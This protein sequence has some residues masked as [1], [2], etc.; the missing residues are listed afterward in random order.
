MPNLQIVDDELV[1]IPKF[2]PLDVLPPN[3]M[4]VMPSLEQL[5]NALYMEPIG[6]KD[7]GYISKGKKVNTD[8]TTTIPPI[9]GPN[10]QGI[11]SLFKQRKRYAD[12]GGLTPSWGGEQS[13]TLPDGSVLSQDQ[14]NELYNQLN[15]P[16]YKKLLMSGSWDNQPVTKAQYVE[17]LLKNLGYNIPT[18][19]TG[20]STPT[21]IEI[22][23]ITSTTTTTNTTTTPSIQNKL[24]DYLGSLYSGPEIINMQDQTFGTSDLPG[25]TGVVSDLRHATAASQVRD[26]IANSVSMGYLNPAGILPQA[27]GLFGSQVLGLGNE[28]QTLSKPTL[29]NLKD[30]WEDIQANWFGGTQVPY[31]QSATATYN[32]LLNNPG[33]PS[34]A[35]YQRTVNVGSSDPGVQALGASIGNLDYSTM[36]ALRNNANLLNTITGQ[37]ANMA[38]GGLTRTIPPVRGP[39]PQGVET[40]FKKR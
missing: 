31:G 18:N 1:T 16:A 2:K 24:Q 20:V 6:I 39:V 26:K 10:P 5:I 40:L 29:Q 28:A 34:A 8:L 7:G 37:T 21:T 33:L 27:L 36:N 30:S 32:Q 12:G 25:D 19:S 11:G 15:D 23:T 4:P 17:N 35:A 3:A 13:H 38:D 22:P 14:I 9:S